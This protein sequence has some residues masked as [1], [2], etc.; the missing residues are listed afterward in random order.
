MRIQHSTISR[1]DFMKGIG[2]AGTGL[3]AVAASTPIFHDMDEVMSTSTWKVKQPWWI[4]EADKPTVEIDWDL[5]ERFDMPTRLIYGTIDKYIGQSEVDRLKTKQASMQ[6]ELL[7]GSEPGLDLKSFALHEGSKFAWSSGAGDFPEYFKEDPFAKA[8]EQL[9]CSKWQGTPEEASKIVTAAL[10]LYGAN[11]VGFSQI[12]DANFRKYFYLR[13]RDYEGP[14][15]DDPKDPRIG[16]SRPGGAML[17]G[18]TYMEP[19]YLFGSTASPTRNIEF[20]DV[21]KP[22][23]TDFKKVIPN[24]YTNI[25]CCAVAQ[26]PNL[27]RRGPAAIKER[28]NFLARAATAQAYG[29]LAI[30]Q[31]R[32]QKFMKT[33]GYGCIAGGTGGLGPVT[34][35]GVWSGMG[36]LNRMNPMIIPEWGTMIRSTIIFVTDLPVAPSKPIDSGIFRFCHTCN[37]CAT[38]CPYQALSMDKEP[39][40][41]L[42]NQANCA[43]AKKYMIHLEQCMQHRLSVGG[44]DNCM[45][46][47]PFGEGSTSWIHDFARAAM[48]NAPI[49]DGFMFN[50]AKIFGYGHIED[51]EEWW[52]EIRP[53]GGLDTTIGTRFRKPY[54]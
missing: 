39:T 48:A 47:C 1:R 15:I 40:W 12:F 35:W 33:L 27:T 28:G 20:E 52:D 41:E 51:P 44:C 21:D 50:M 54:T 6:K 42:H 29:N 8:P 16:Q 34:P 18:S 43:G 19:K 31:R 14:V 26:D 25:I 36:E 24:K 13:G 9:G 49:L 53:Y 46:N 7:N 17:F 45:S 11:I 30:V 2:L 38:A 3:G 10:R 32:F 4:K 37:K 5:T 23:T 22:Y